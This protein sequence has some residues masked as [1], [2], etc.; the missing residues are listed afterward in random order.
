MSDFGHS[1]VGAQGL[2]E[3]RRSGSDEGAQRSVLRYSMSEIDGLMLLGGTLVLA[4]IGCLAYA[5][6]QRRRELSSVGYSRQYPGGPRFMGDGTQE[7]NF[8]QRSEPGGR[9]GRDEVEAAFGQS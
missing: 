6:A 5:T 2:S 7:Q 9:I 8:G 1:D 3:E 4:G